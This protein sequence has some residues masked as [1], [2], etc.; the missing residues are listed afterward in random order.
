MPQRVEY[1]ALPGTR[2]DQYV[3]KLRAVLDSLAQPGGTKFKAFR[4]H[5]RKLGIWDR[6][7]A[8]AMLSL[9]DLSWDRKQVEV[10]PLARRLMEAQDDEQ[11]RDL[12]FARLRRDNILLV[13]YVLEALDV[14]AGGRLHS[15]HELYRMITSYVFPGEY[16]TLGNFQAWF[17][18]LAA[19]GYIKLV[20]IRWALSDKGLK[21]ISEF[22]GMDV[23]EILEDLEEEE[24]LGEGAV[25]E[26]VEP[27][28]MA[29]SGPG[30]GPVDERPAAAAEE[31]DDDLFADLPPEPE[32][33]SEEAVARAQAKFE[34]KF[35]AEEEAAPAAPA[36]QA[37]RPTAAV[38]P[39]A[40]LPTGGA[41]FAPAVIGDAAETRSLVARIT[42]WWRQWSDWPSWTAPALG[43]AEAPD[44]PGDDLLLELGVLALL[45]EGLPVQPQAFAFVRRIREA[46]FFDAVRGEGGLGAA[47]DAVADLDGEPWARP[48]LERLVHA[49]GMARRVASEP[50]MLAALK[51]ARDGASAVAHLRTALFGGAGTEAPFWVLRELIRLGVLDGAR[52]A[53]AAVVPTARLLHNAWRIGLI[54]RPEATA[55]EELV[56]ASRSV[57]TLFDADTGWG[58]ALERLDLGLGLTA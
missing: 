8:P 3:G 36:P 30:P 34:A 39:H 10:G 2:P 17:D 31:E 11:F 41:A 1:E 29:E 58:E 22:R 52:V 12:L 45:V 42:G 33:P 9:I 44:P 13:K 32:P 23:E 5:L 21:V 6:E 54:T 18:W 7:K 48:L 51:D 40:P 46:G 25:A 38:T 43:C 47:L 26:A 49:G 28:P 50:G 37:A 24:E 35:G 14:E 19:T 20:G 15:V 27:A 53:D 56:A 55:F 4:S 57:S 16:V